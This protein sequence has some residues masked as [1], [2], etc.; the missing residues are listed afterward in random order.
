MPKAFHIYTIKEA[1]ASGFR[2]R[3]APAPALRACET[4]GIL[5]SLRGFN[6][7]PQTPAFACLFEALA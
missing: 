2:A 6:T 5:T 1:S 4:S 7:L 3:R